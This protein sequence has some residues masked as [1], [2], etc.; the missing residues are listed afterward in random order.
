ML[1]LYTSDKEAL[2]SLWQTLIGRLQCRPFESWSMA[3]PFSEDNYSLLRERFLA[4]YLALKETEC[5]ITGC[6]ATLVT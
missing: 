6:Q 5:F 1:T 4:C 3:L 2:W